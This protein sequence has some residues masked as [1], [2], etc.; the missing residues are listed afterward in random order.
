MAIDYGRLL[1][2]PAAFRRQLCLAHHHPGLRGVEQLFF[3]YC[4]SRYRSCRYWRA[5][6]WSGYQVHQDHSAAKYTRP[7]LIKSPCRAMAAGRYSA[8]LNATA[9]MMGR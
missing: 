1:A 5:G 3:A 7:L 8:T 4:S 2:L 6:K 9:P